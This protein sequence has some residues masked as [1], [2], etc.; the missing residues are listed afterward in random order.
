MAQLST[1]T[2][3]RPPETPPSARDATM[4]NVLSRHGSRHSGNIAELNE[5]ASRLELNWTYPAD[6]SEASLLLDR[7]RREM[8]GLGSRLVAAHPRAFE[9][10]S[11]TASEKSR[12]VESAR[13][14]LGGAGLERDVAT[15]PLNEDFLLRFFDNCGLKKVPIPAYDAYVAHHNLTNDALLAYEGCA[16]DV[17]LERPP[18]WCWMDLAKLERA[19][20]LKMYY[21]YASGLATLAASYLLVDFFDAFDRRTTALRFAHDSTLACFL[22][23]LGVLDESFQTSRVLP[24]AANL[25]ATLHESSDDVLV[26]FAL[27]ERDLLLPAC[28]GQLYCRLD[29][30]R[31][32]YAPYLKFRPATPNGADVCNFARRLH[33]SQTTQNDAAARGEL[34]R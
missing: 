8:A 10:I 18:A 1:K 30:L 23:L 16:Y 9:R 33:A 2:A 11:V 26:K 25:V 22:G 7:G 14:F 6:A 28:Q 12:C 15:R 4:V 27:N 29:T 21:G 31:A 13:A 19:K 24:M 32:A 34:R 5:L 3:Y 20:D 17:L